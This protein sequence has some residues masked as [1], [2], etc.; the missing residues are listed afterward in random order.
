[1]GSPVGNMVEM[2]G[3][4]AGS[5]AHSNSRGATADKSR[6]PGSGQNTVELTLRQVAHKFLPNSQQELGSRMAARAV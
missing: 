1:M 3:S 5:L 4:Q 2:G 6:L